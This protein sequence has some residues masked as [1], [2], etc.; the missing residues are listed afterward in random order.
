MK[1]YN[2]DFEEKIKDYREVCL[3]QYFSTRVLSVQSRTSA[4]SYRCYN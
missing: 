3:L 4:R 1:K 2:R